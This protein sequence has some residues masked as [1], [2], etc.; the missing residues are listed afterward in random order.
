MIKFLHRPLGAN[1]P[2]ANY[3]ILTNKR[4]TGVSAGFRFGKF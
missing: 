1:P 2:G 3:Q 4:L